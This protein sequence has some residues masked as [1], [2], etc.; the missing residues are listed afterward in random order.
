ML[1]KLLDLQDTAKAGLNAVPGEW[2]VW[3]PFQLVLSAVVTICMPG[4]SKVL[5]AAGP[6][7]DRLQQVEVL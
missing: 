4:Q 7:L 6:A 2:V 5:K 1:W 3:T